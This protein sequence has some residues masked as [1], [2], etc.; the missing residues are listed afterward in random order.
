MRLYYNFF[1]NLKNIKNKIIIFTNNKAKILSFILYRNI[2]NYLII[3]FLMIFFN[4]TNFLKMFLNFCSSQFIGYVK[5]M[6]ITL[7]I[8]FKDIISFKYI[9][10]QILGFIICQ[11]LSNRLITRF[12]MIF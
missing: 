10:P 7:K 5:I 11:K 1:N 2:L 3:R 8:C 12:L 4:F 9:K 6:L